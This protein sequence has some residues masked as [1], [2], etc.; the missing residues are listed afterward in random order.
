MALTK[1]TLIDLNSNELILD[2]DADTSI[3]ADTDDT[4]H[5]KIAGSDELVMTGTALTPAV[6]DGSA[7]GSTTLEWSD[8]FL[9][10]GAVINFG[11]DQDINI[12]HVADTGLTTNADFTVGDDLFVSGGLIDLK[13]TGTVSTIKFYCESSNAHAQSLV[14]A[15]HSEGATNTL[16][17]PGTGGDARLVSTTSTATLTN[18]TLTTPVIAEIDSGSTIT[19]DATTDIVLDADGG[20]IFF[21]D[22][23]TTFGSA[24][25]TSGNLIIKSG[26]TTAATF[27]GANVTLA[28]TVA[29]GAITSSG[30]IKT[31][32]T[33]E[34]TST[35]DGSLQTDG[36]LSVAKDIVAGDD[37]K[38][39][40]DSAVLS[41]G[42]DGD[43]TL[44]HD[45]TTGLTIAATPISIDS[46][47]EL[48]L[49][50]TTGDIKLQDGGTDQIAFDLD[51]TAGE[52]IMKP[53]VDS[54]DL[55]ISQYDGTEV[56]RIEDNA[57][58]GLVG[59]KLSIANSS[60]DVVIKPLTDAKDIIFQ[61]YDGTVVATVEDNATF[62][63]PASK[64]AIGGTAVTATAAEINLIDGGTAR[65]TTALADGDGIL[66]N[67][68]GTMRMTNVT[69]VKTYMGGANTPA[70]EAYKNVS[71]NV[72]DDTYE[73][74][75][76]D[77]EIFD[78]GSCYDH[79]SNYRFT[80]DVAGK[81]FVYLT[82]WMSTEAN[83]NFEV[84]WANI[85]KNGSSHAR[86][87]ISAYSSNALRDCSLT[88]CSTVV[89]NGSDDYVEAY[90][91][92]DDNNM[93]SNPRIIGGNNASKF[94]AF[95]IL[96]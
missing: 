27:S 66:I 26:T 4:I 78:V 11:A 64:L 9:A 6:A 51:G 96:E 90:S 91:R 46:T 10:D 42:A 44:T 45:G 2:L 48:H 81:Y 35:T 59:N 67:D 18:K 3:T 13:N 76:F 5:F 20:D 41:L 22:A 80:P 71:A 29:S 52:V 93:S 57:S 69:T 89:M 33:T 24:T 31:D 70:F 16:T 36:G 74:I 14:A 50:S 55:V 83:G 28:G 19:L 92:I 49:N 73:K 8:L 53:A 79:S 75:P 62:N 65:G 82:C 37:V 39:L 94:G 58:L 30:I 86:Q 77:T 34:A 88:V 60:S 84:M 15:P 85:Y 68:N 1:A 12:T 61:Q 63:I 40:S 54:D 87:S 47:G 25:N 72:S 43:A 7:L 56:I 38:L 95:R 23:G 32:D 21:K 17:L